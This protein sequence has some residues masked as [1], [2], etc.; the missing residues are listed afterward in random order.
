MMRACLFVSLTAVA[1]YPAPAQDLAALCR[2]AAHPPV[3]SWSEYEFVG[4]QQN[5]AK[6][7]ISVV[8]TEAVGD[9][10]FLW[11]EMAMDS[12]GMGPG[13]GARTSGVIKM[14]VPNFGPGMG[15]P[16][17]AIMKLAGTP[18]MTLPL[19]DALAGPD[20]A[21]S[22]LSRCE[23]SKSLGWENVIVPAGSF[24]ALH[25]Q[26]PD[27][28]SDEWV[29][30]NLPLGLVRAVNDEQSGGGQMVLVN[31]GTGA[32]TSITEKPVPFDPQLM[33][34]MMGQTSH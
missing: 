15:H 31:H 19:G 27:S 17:T 9:T 4:G 28:H 23:D 30:P 1:A 29:V 25:V 18:A 10:S 16:H 5:G 2:E 11:I 12:V 20:N 34:Q 32:T 3:G 7:R 33:M 26:D 13:F 8:G 24:R 14:L 21:A 22:G 6:I